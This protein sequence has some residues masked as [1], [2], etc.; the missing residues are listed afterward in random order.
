MEL[1][2]QIC[3]LFSIPHFV[4][5][6][7]IARNK[8]AFQS[9]SAFPLCPYPSFVTDSDIS[10]DNTATEPN[11]KCTK[12]SFDAER[13][14]WFAVDLGNNYIIQKVCLLSGKVGSLLEKFNITVG[15]YLQGETSFCNYVEGPVKNPTSTSFSNYQCFDCREGSAIGSF[16][17]ITKTIKGSRLEL[18]DIDVAGVFH[19]QS[20]Y[21]EINFKDAQLTSSPLY[22][23]HA[24]ENAIDKNYCTTYHSKSVTDQ[25]YLLV[26]YTKLYKFFGFVITRRPNTVNRLRHTYASV[27]TKPDTTFDSK[28]LFCCKDKTHDR[29]TPLASLIIKCDEIYSGQFFLIHQ[30]NGETKLL[31]EIFELHIYGQLVDTFQEHKNTISQKPAI[32]TIKNQGTLVTPNEQSSLLDNKFFHASPNL[33]VETDNLIEISSDLIY[34]NTVCLSF[35]NG[36][37][38]KPNDNIEIV[39]YQTNEKI[40]A[41]LNGGYDYW[42]TTCTDLKKT[43]FSN[44]CKIIIKG[45]KFIHEIDFLAISVKSKEYIP[46]SS[47]KKCEMRSSIEINLKNVTNPHRLHFLVEYHHENSNSNSIVAGGN[48]FLSRQWK[49]CESLK[50]SEENEYLENRAFFKC[51]T[52]FE[53]IQVFNLNRMERSSLH[54]YL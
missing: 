9:T 22:I 39:D 47:P 20:D 13:Y 32:R 31:I 4:N 16:L 43:I 8:V 46:Y 11:Y 21:K 44:Y 34:L 50:I 36:N 26:T 29:L 48:R 25:P 37:T 40:T 38:R 17:I 42:H 12:T 19:S 10:I 35:D 33:Q 27:K 14:S 49:M 28:A 51:N 6:I 30:Y 18:C 2:I 3:L 54:V 53:Y 41:E 1:F 24:A 45:D 5:S 23:N 52:S 7:N 15:N